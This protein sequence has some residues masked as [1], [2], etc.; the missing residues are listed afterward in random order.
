MR[1]PSEALRERGPSPGEFARP[2]AD[3]LLT[4]SS[5]EKEQVC[6]GRV[7]PCKGRSLVWTDNGSNTD[8][9]SVQPPR[10]KMNGAVHFDRVCSM[11]TK[12]TFSAG[13]AKELSGLSSRQLNDWEARGAVQSERAK[14]GEW[15]KFT[16]KQAFALVV[17]SE[18]RRVC[19]VPVGQVSWIVDFMN[20]EKA[21]HFE[22]ALDLMKAG[23]HVFLL[24]DLERTFVM[25]SDLEIQDLMMHGFFRTESHSSHVLLRL[26]HLVNRLLGLKGIPPLEA[27]RDFYEATMR[28]RAQLS[29]RTRAE[30]EVLQAVRTGGFD[31]VEIKLKDGKVTQISGEGSVSAADVSEDGEGVTVLNGEEFETVTLTKS[32]GRVTHVK[33]RVPKKYGK[34]ENE[35]TLFVVA[36]GESEEDK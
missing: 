5:S 8:Q 9:H 28:G 25:D 18:L 17:A 19:H 30:M 32:N 23:L 14:A 16:A 20:Q 33:R 3:S 35:G 2:R 27:S 6:A 13:E 34:T 10:P 22:A 24:T 7:E 4:E 11:S 36:V 1:A 26:N 29:V 31:K 12:D 15:R 21:N